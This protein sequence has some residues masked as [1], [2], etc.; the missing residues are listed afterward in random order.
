MNILYTNFHL[1]NG[2]GHTTYLSYLFNGALSNGINVFMAAPGVSRLNK[3]LRKD[4]PDRVFD[5]EFPGKPK[6]L[7]NMLRNAKK[8]KNIIVEKQINI[9]HV[10]GTPDHKVVMFCQWL[11]RL[12]FSIIR[13]KHDSFVIKENW[14]ADKLYGKYTDR[15]ITVSHYQFNHVI[16]EQL[17]NKTSVI[18][19]GV[20]LDYYQ[21]REKSIDLIKQFNIQDQDIVFISVAGTAL[22]KGWQFL[23]EAAS[24]LDDELRYKVK[25]IIVGNAPKDE[26]VERYVKQF[27]MEDNVIFTGFM[28]DVR[29]VI[30]IADIGFVLSIGVETISFACREMMAMGKPTLVSDHAGLSEN[31]D[32]NQN[33]WVVKQGSVDQIQFFLQKVGQLNLSQ[34]SDLATQKA[35][36]E[37]GLEDFLSETIASYQGLR[38]D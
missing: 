20:D 12:D 14:F 11:Y 25:I 37:F 27:N 22:H 16:T 13:T 10:N 33:G 36:S 28:S 9:V 29:E 15:M 3:D 18:H 24:K 4:Y 38:C 32:E 1:G 19:N 5:I 30:S 21:P 34:H 17:R 8:L 26:I 31:I 35:K 6:E 7:L 23:V 2:G